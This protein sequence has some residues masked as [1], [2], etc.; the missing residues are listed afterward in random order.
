MKEI[1]AP[2]DSQ[3]L[4]LFTMFYTFQV[5]RRISPINSMIRSP[6][7]SNHQEL[8][9]GSEDREARQADRAKKIE[10][11]Q[12]RC[13]DFGEVPKRIQNMNNGH[14]THEDSAKKQ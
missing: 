4:P 2:V 10:K 14:N 8:S 9:M 3:N 5:V 6:S 7:E 1:P 11:E 12:L 13:G